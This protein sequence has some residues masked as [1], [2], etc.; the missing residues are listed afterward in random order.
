MKKVFMFLLLTTAVTAYAQDSFDES[1]SDNNDEVAYTEENEEAE[2]YLQ[3][4]E[5]QAYVSAPA[6]E[7]SEDYIAD[8]EVYS[9]SDIEYND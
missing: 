2:M 9:S 7:S 8:E 5:D 6:P 4:Q 3:T 1:P